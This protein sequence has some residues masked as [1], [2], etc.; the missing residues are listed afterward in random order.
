LVAV[1]EQLPLAS[2]TERTLP[3]TEQ[4]VEAPTLK[5]TAPV[6]LP[7]VVLSADVL[8]YATVEGVATVVR[9]A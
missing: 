8:P 6:P 2:I 4:P 9:V 1:T 3:V 5:V 7:P